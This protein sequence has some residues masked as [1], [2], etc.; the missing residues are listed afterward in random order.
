MPECG[1]HDT[2]K[3]TFEH[4]GSWHGYEPGRPCQSYRHM[5]ISAGIRRI[6]HHVPRTVATNEDL[7]EEFGDWDI[8]KIY[9]KTGINVRG[10]AADGECAS[11]LGVAAAQKLLTSSEVRPGD[12]DYLIF[13][14]QSPDYFLPATAC[15]MQHR[16][17]LPTS[18]AAIDINQG[19]SGFVYGLSIAKGLI[20]SGIAQN[21]LLI[22]ADTY[23]RYIH[24]GDRSVRTIFGDAAAATWISGVDSSDPL[25]GPFIL[26]T[27]GRGACNLIVRA[28]GN[29]VPLTDAAREVKTDEGGNTRSDANLYMNGP[30]IFTFTLR[31]VPAAVKSLLDKAGIGMDA[32]DYFVFHQANR[33]MLEQLRRKIDIP[34]EKFCINL[35]SFGNTVSSTIPISL[36]TAMMNGTISSGARVMLVG[37]GVGY[38]W[39]AAMVQV[40]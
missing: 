27:D 17:G 19:C 38:S 10:V 16:L 34:P 14:T 23:T 25:I 30:E 8:N 37:F 3:I 9:D 7:A 21:V 15:L 13:C 22:T 4:I 40:I 29:R 26:G 31:Q 33:F 12:I 39:G 35:E 5:S 36:Q 2:I 1:P 6:F 20:E 32:V 28:G 18:C 11:D 24:A